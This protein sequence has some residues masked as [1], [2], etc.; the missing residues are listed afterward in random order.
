VLAIAGIS[1]LLLL[2]V[3]RVAGA[4]PLPVCD[5]VGSLSLSR[6]NR[7]R[8]LRYVDVSDDAQKRCGKCSFFTGGER[9]CGKCQLLAGGAVSASGVCASFAARNK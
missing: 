1:P 3:W 2:G 5:N 8:S 4:Q 6:R 7:R 9:N